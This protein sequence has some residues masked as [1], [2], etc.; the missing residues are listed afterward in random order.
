MKYLFVN[1]LLFT[2]IYLIKAQTKEETQKWIKEKIELYAF[3]D[4]KELFYN[5][6][7]KFSETDIIIEDNLLSKVGGVP[8]NLKTKYWIPIKE[9]TKIRF[10][11]KGSTIWLYFKIYEGKKLIKRKNP[12]LTFVSEVALIL[13]K[14][15]SEKNLENRLLKAFKHLI[16]IH[17]GNIVEETF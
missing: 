10:E 13:E 2:S 4:D 7:V 6:L 9:L 12:E 8:V 5:Y 1:L 14:S 15:I 3:S 11:N 16:K 17:G